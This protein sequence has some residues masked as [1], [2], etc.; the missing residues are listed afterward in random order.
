MVKANSSR[1]LR[2][3][4]QRVLIEKGIVEDGEMFKYDKQDD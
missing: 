3:K 4:L 2:L 1:L